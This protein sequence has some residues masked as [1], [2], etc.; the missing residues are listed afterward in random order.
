[1]SEKQLNPEFE[2]THNSAVHSSGD[3]CVNV[4]VN[5]GTINYV[6][7]QIKQERFK[8]LKQLPRDILNFVGRSE[9]LTEVEGVLRQG[10]GATIAISALSGM[11][12]V[13]KSAL[14]IRVAHRLKDDYP[15]AQLYVN[16]QGADRI[17]CRDPFSV[18]G[19]LL[20]ELGLDEKLVVTMNLESRSKWW[21]SVLAELRAIVVLDNAR[22]AAQVWQLL[23]GSDGPCAVIVTSRQELALDDVARL[24]LAAMTIEDA[25]LLLSVMSERSFDAV[26]LEVAAKVVEYCGRLPLAIKI[27]GAL[28]RKRSQMSLGETIEALKVERDRLTA[29]AKQHQVLLTDEYLD[30]RSSLSLSLKWLTVEER[31]IF[32]KVAVIP[33]VD[34]GLQVA[35]FVTDLKTVQEGLD[36]LADEQLLEA[37]GEGR[38]EFH[39]LVRLLGREQWEKEEEWL[40]LEARA[41]SWY[42]D[43]TKQA[44]KLLEGESTALA[45]SW[46][47]QEW[48]NLKA[49]VVTAADRSISLVVIKMPNEMVNYSLGREHSSEIAILLEISLAKAQKLNDRNGEAAS[50]GN[51]GNAYRFLGQYQRA[52]DLYQQLNEIA[53]EIGCRNREAVSLGGLGNMYYFLSQYQRAIDF[54]QQQHEIAHEIGDRNSEACSLGGLGNAHNSLGQY[55]RAIKFHQQYNEIAREI[56]D[57]NGEA[58]SLGNLGLAY[59][60]LGQYQRAIEFHQQCFEIVCEIGDRKGKAA[61]LGNLGLAYASLG[62]YQRAIEFHQQNNEIVREIGDRNSEANSLG[63]LGNAYYS[64]GQYQRAIDFYQKQNNIAHEIGNRNG[65]ANSLNG[66]GNTYQ[67]L[68]QYQR[69]IDFYQKQNKIVGEICDRYGESASLCGLGNAYRSLGQYQHAIDF[70]QQCFEIM[71]EIGNRNGEAT[72]LFT[73]ALSLAKLDN[74]GQ[75]LLNLQKAKLIYEEIQLD[76]MV[77]Q[78]DKALRNWNQLIAI[79]RHSSP[80]IAD[81]SPKEITIDWYEREKQ[82]NQKKTYT[83]AE[84]K[85]MNRQTL[86]FCVGLA[87]VFLVWKLKN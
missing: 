41:I 59:D 61:S 68:G 63:N 9:Q 10:N 22:D 80:A 3:Y 73:M 36:R 87:V 45:V 11:G 16:L 14:A 72:S 2:G 7:Q 43:L 13:G 47:K 21:R 58:N 24:R 1:M 40:A 34:F 37:K 49:V 8:A 48:Q 77:K 32:E 70:H 42:F 19:E 15:D 44:T 31:S 71:H 46:F 35:E 17:N 18:L 6:V 33:G 50:L 38:Y 30:V 79:E 55:Q 78:C 81:Q 23:P 20:V 56:G 53:R 67:S 51:L 57:R 65:E 4:A 84:I 69:A 85:A 66:L 64:L 27:V 26:E 75:A 83:N 39:D 5:H 29:F 54:Y 82:A 52:I 12:G 62:Q 86:W 28:L 25:R 60:S 76:H 74:H